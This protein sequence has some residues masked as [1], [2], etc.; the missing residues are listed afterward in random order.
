[1]S[2][3]A[4]DVKPKAFHA[5]EGTRESIAVDPVAEKKLVRKIDL[6][7]MP[8]VFILY[9]FSYVDRSNLGLAKVAG[10]EEDLELT[11]DQYYTAVIMWVIGYTIA[12]VP[13]K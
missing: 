5:E 7:L 11:S 10:M 12:A 2:L 8:S 1:M 6:H 4:E 13:S 9:L 3:G